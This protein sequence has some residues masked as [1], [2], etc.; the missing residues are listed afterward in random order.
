[1]F[2]SHNNPVYICV[3][4]VMRGSDPS[5]NVVL[6]EDLAAVTGVAVAGTCM[7]LSLAY[8]SH[9]PDAVGSIIIGTI[10]AGVSGFIIKTNGNALLS[11]LVSR[12]EGKT[13]Q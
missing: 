12:Q 6:M 9:L 8:S 2:S 10:L 1:M 5:V 13:H 11:R 4:V 7:Y 3:F